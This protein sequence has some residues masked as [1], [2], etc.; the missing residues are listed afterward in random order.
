MPL[1]NLQTD[2]RSLQYG[3]DRKGGGSSNQ[4]YLVNPIPDGVTFNAP[5]FLLRQGT[6][7]NFTSVGNIPDI[8]LTAGFNLTGQVGV[9]FNQ[10]VDVNILKINRFNVLKTNAAD[11]NIP[12]PDDAFR[13]SS[14]FFDTRSP[15]GFL[16]TT[17]QL[18][19]EQQ[20]APVYGL[21]NRIYNPG[22]T[23]SQ[24]AVLPLG[25]HLNKK[26]LNPFTPGYFAEGANSD[27]YY[28]ATLSVERAAD[29]EG[30]YNR[31][32][33]LYKIKQTNTANDLEKIT[34]ASFY[35][36]NTTNGSLLFTYPGGP[37]SP[38]PI[39]GKTNIRMPGMG[40]FGDP[41]ERTNNTTVLLDAINISK[42]FGNTSSIAPP[43]VEPLQ[44][45]GT[46]LLLSIDRA[47]NPKISTVFGTS[48]SE[49]AFFNREYTYQTSVTNYTSPR[50]SPNQSVNSDVLNATKVLVNSSSAPDAVEQI[51]I[52]QNS[53]LVK[54]FFEIIDNNNTSNAFGAGD[55]YLF[56]RAYVNSINDSFSPEWNSYKYVGRAENFYKYGGF[57][58]EIQLSFSVYAHSRAEMLPIYQKLNYL[59][60]TTAPNYSS[61]GLMRGVFLKLTVGDYFRSMPGI[62]K[63]ITLKPSFDAGWD[64]NR[65]EDGVPFKAEED[66][67]NFV[68]QLPKMIDIDLSFTPIHNITP[69]YQQPFIRNDL[70]YFP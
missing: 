41:R 1:I 65:D 61:I 60:G 30:I 32:A 14:F 67:I 55:N 66:V 25:Y 56:F 63:S 27:G 8:N 7:S 59:V 16:F 19:L 57:S 21:P 69:E 47:Y 46:T 29:T 24:A 22:N 70:N 44:N 26:G 64:I 45:L 58:R 4:P 48:A 31:L 9:G 23:I 28:K 37:N 62:V 13:L 51:Q 52:L 68:G 43:V 35:Y 17:K 10:S 18:L 54:F 39:L 50:I 49:S 36:I 38:L 40:G 34:G 2:L 33:L 12:V 11:L 6:L 53:D 15:K 3:Q 20:N 42:N 5:D